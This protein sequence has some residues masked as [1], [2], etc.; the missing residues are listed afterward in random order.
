MSIRTLWHRGAALLVAAILTGCS[1]LD[2]QLSAAAEK[3]SDVYSQLSSIA[4]ENRA[5]LTIDLWHG[6]DAEDAAGLVQVVEEF[7][8]T[9]GKENFV[10]IRLTAYEGTEAV[11]AAVDKAIEEEKTKTDDLRRMPALFFAL[12]DTA[13]RMDR[14]GLAVHMDEFF[15]QN[16]IDTLLDAVKPE[17]FPGEDGVITLLPVASD[18]TVL[19]VNEDAWM[20]FCSEYSA[21]TD[22]ETVF[23]SS[24]FATFEGISA[25]AKAYQQWLL[26]PE[27]GEEP[28]DAAAMVKQRSPFFAADSWSRLMTGAYR[29]KD[30]T[31][32]SVDSESVR[33]SF[34][35]DKVRTFWDFW[36]D[37]VLHGIFAETGS[38]EAFASGDA[39]CCLVSA[40]D[41]CDYDQKM[42]ISEMKVYQTPGFEDGMPVTFQETL[43]LV[44]LDGGQEHKDSVKI[45]LQYLME[46]EHL[47]RVAVSSGRLPTTKASVS[48]E[49]LLSAFEA[50]GLSKP[51]RTI[52]TRTKEQLYSHIQ[53]SVAVFSD[54]SELLE[55]MD[56]LLFHTAK[57][58]SGRYK[59]VVASG[60][61][62]QQT[63]DLMVNDIQYDRWYTAFRDALVEL[64]LIGGGS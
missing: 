21:Q 61:D 37:G 19:L 23:D 11:E 8:E 20:D 3:A 13:Y 46:P 45:F 29:G 10:R 16:E 44:A 63:Y 38:R 55:T 35:R 47:A 27:E 57:I 14:L 24:S 7:N 64:V 28:L 42:P 50:Q 9:V 62:P 15:S 26:L 17:A 1:N 52:L 34:E 22:G 53:H 60:L 2:P 49:V 58:M 4:V 54:G 18:S 59:T 32:F 41:A 30:G 43:G 31:M 48:D 5:P 51:E 40:S 36:Y 6:F 12:D 33:F 25:A 39:V 56:Q